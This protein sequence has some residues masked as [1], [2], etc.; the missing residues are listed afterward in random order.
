MLNTKSLNH[1]DL[2]RFVALSGVVL[3]HIWPRYLPG[4]WAGVD[5]F[6]VLS[7]YLIYKKLCQ[8]NEWTFKQITD[9]YA[10]RVMRLAPTW[11]FV[12][13]VTGILVFVF[14]PLSL[15]SYSQDGLSA[16]LF[17][18]N[19]R[20]W[21]HLGDYW[22]AQ[23]SLLLHTWSLSI[24]EQWY[25][26]LPIGL[27]MKNLKV[28]NYLGVVLFITSFLIYFA[29]A[30]RESN[31]AFYFTYCRVWEFI[32]GASLALVPQYKTVRTVRSVLIFMFLS[33]I[34]AVY[35]LG[36]G[37]IPPVLLA[38]SFSAIAIFLANDY[39]SNLPRITVPLA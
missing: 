35:L 15:Q 24:E 18:S 16:A 10:S 39:Q 3:F 37:K 14:R 22:K 21:R 38:T 19:F 1:L 26:F 6:F 28:R 27:L 31:G 23:D 34:I 30:I 13:S 9:F 5:V 7:G 8:S 33:S 29:L 11:L 2:I 12:V 32:L 25:V 20:F 4:G 36:T 17:L